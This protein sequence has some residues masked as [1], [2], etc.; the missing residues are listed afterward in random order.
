VLGSYPLVEGYYMAYELLAETVNACLDNG[1]VDFAVKL[2][3]MDEVYDDEILHRIAQAVAPESPEPPFP[4]EGDTVRWSTLGGDHYEGPVV[5]VDSNVLYVR[6][7]DG[8]VR[9]VE[10]DGIE[11]VSMIEKRRPAADP[12]RKFT[13]AVKNIYHNHVNAQDREGADEAAREAISALIQEFEHLLKYNLD[14]LDQE[15]GGTKFHIEDRSTI[16]DSRTVDGGYVSFK[17][18]YPSR[19]KHGVRCPIK[20]ESLLRAACYEVMEM[21]GFS[22]EQVDRILYADDLRPHML[23]VLQGAADSLKHRPV[24]GIKLVNAAEAF[25]LEH[26]KV[27]GDGQLQLSATQAE[28]TTTVSLEDVAIETTFEVRA[29][30]EWPGEPS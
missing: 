18:E 14:Y 19:L 15:A 6:C 26:T 16:K 10:G 2:L 13:D 30:V 8:K 5:E 4:K 7:A 23:E 22:K 17:A 27:E 29:R 3:E 28:R 1:R 24:E 21:T 12:Y 9:P 11:V 25:A 20:W